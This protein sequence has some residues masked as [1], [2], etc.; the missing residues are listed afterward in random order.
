MTRNLKETATRSNLMRAFEGE[1]MARNRYTIYSSVAK[2]EGY[3]QIASILIEIAENER[4]HAKLFYKYLDGD[5]VN[6]LNYPHAN[7]PSCLGKTIDNLNCAAEGEKEEC[8]FLYPLF[9]KIAVDEGFK[10]ISKTFDLVSKIEQHHM[11]VLKNFAK[12]IETNT[13]FSKEKSTKWVCAKCG[14]ISEGTTPPAECPVCHHD[15]S[16]FSV[17]CCC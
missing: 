16:Y 10:D 4:E 11:S 8:E 5:D 7:F 17:L 12:Q 3:E 1:S 15:I 6:M 9:S 13:V 14:H 2:K